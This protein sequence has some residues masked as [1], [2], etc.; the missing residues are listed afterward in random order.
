VKLEPGE[1][2]CVFFDPAS[3]PSAVKKED[4]NG[5]LRW[6]YLADVQTEDGELKTFEFSG[7]FKKLLM[8]LIQARQFFIRIKRIGE[9]TDTVY[10]PEAC[11]SFELSHIL[12]PEKASF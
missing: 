1:S 11:P 12:P 6:R 4:F 8:P 2:I 9:G 7:K 3:P 10:D 5:K